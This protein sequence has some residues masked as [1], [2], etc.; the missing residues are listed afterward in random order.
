MLGLLEQILFDPKMTPREKEKKLRK[1]KELHPNIYQLR[2][3]T[4]ESEPDYMQ[5]R[6]SE[7]GGAITPSRKASLAKLRSAMRI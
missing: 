4:P 5:S 6:R 2:F 3:P 7:V 1:F